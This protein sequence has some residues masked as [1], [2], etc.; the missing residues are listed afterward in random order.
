MK[1]L[2]TGDWHLGKLVNEYSML[3]EQRYI[4]N[5]LF[6]I[7][8]REQPDCMIISGDVYDRSIPPKEAVE[9]FDEALNKL[10][11]EYELP[12]LIISGNHDS[13]ERLDFG[14]ELFQ[15][16]EVFIEGTFSPDVRI[17][18]LL[19]EYG[20]VHFYLVPYVN[21]TLA[22]HLYDDSSIQTHQDVIEKVVDSITF[23]NERRV[24]I[25]HNFF[26]GKIDE[27]YTS[28]SERSLSVGGT[29]VIDIELV[30]DFDYVALGHI[31]RPQ[32]IEHDHIRYSGSI[33]KYSVSEIHTT[34]GVYI[35]DLK[36][37]GE[38]DITFH[39]LE[40]R[41]DFIKIEG[42]LEDLL[43]P[44]FYT[45]VDRDS[46]IHAVL[47]DEKELYD[48]MRQL[49]AVYPN[50]LQIDRPNFVLETYQGARHQAVKTKAPLELY[51]DFYLEMTGQEL[52]PSELELIKQLL[53]DAFREGEQ[54]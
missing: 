31:H 11:L 32:R 23:D 42:R 6:K 19:D 4:L 35:V 7:I 51:E 2:H 52:E 49:R 33:L 17:V 1:I 29:D 25:N 12:V 54:S 45:T 10:S 16:S 48:P 30:K 22:R 40:P 47:T 13:G 46:Y 36:E 20:P 15:K 3:E 34:K 37:K 18:T 50:I 9:L 28:D 53:T 5:E 26:A 27:V 14:K 39:R 8:E 21:P 41:H 44:E 24:F 43:R 38:V